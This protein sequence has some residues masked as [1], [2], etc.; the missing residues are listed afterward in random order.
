MFLNEFKI[1][2][3]KSTKFFLK[4]KYTFF[5]GKFSSH[6]VVCQKCKEDKIDQNNFTDSSLQ[7]VNATLSQ[8][9]V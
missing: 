9:I 7:Q 8:R 3:L 5:V 4:L 1:K 6:I 2:N